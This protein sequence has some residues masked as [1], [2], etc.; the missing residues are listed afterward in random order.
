MISDI[1][2]EVFREARW[3]RFSSW[4]HDHFQPIILIKGTNICKRQVAAITGMTLADLFQPF[5][6]LYRDDAYLTTATL[7][8]K[9]RNSEYGV[10]QKLSKWRRPSTKASTKDFSSTVA[11]NLIE[12][13][14][15]FPL[16]PLRISVQIPMAV[17]S[18][19]SSGSSTFPPLMKGSFGAAGT[20]FGKSSGSPHTLREIPSFRV[21]FVSEDE[22]TY[23][24][25]SAYITEAFRV[26]SESEPD[27]SHLK[28]DASDIFTLPEISPPSSAG[29]MT[30]F[31]ANLKETVSSD[32]RSLPSSTPIGTLNPPE[33][34]SAPV[35]SDGGSD[36]TTLPTSGGE[37]NP[38]NRCDGSSSLPSLSTLQESYPSSVLMNSIDIQPLPL[39]PTEVSA[40]NLPKS[41]TSSPVM[42]SVNNYTPIL[43]N[44]IAGD[45]ELICRDMF[46]RHRELLE[47]EGVELPWYKNWSDVVFR[48]AQWAL[49]EALDQPVGIIYVVSSWEEDPLAALL[50]LQKSFE[51]NTSLLTAGTSIAKSIIFLD[52][53]P[54]SL[55]ECQNEKVPSSSSSSTSL[56]YAMNEQ[57]EEI[58]SH[59]SPSYE[60]YKLSIGRVAPSTL[61]EP[62]T[63]TMQQHI[64]SLYIPHLSMHWPHLRDSTAS[65]YPFHDYILSCKDK[66]LY[67]LPPPPYISIRECIYSSEPLAVASYRAEGGENFPMF[68]RGLNW[69]DLQRIQEIARTFIERAV[70]DCM[71][72]SIEMLDKRVTQARKGIKNQ[73]KLFWRNPRTGAAATAVS[74]AEQAGGAAEA[75]FSAVGGFFQV[76][77][78][79]ATFLDDSEY[80]KEGENVHRSHV[81][82]RIPPVREFSD[83]SILWIGRKLAD[84]NF[85]IRDYHRALLHY[86]GCVADYKHEKSYL[87]LGISAC[88]NSLVFKRV[89][90]AYPCSVPSHSLRCT[91]IVRV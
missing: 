41:S 87:H 63:L 84:L 33:R 83:D 20:A 90:D 60:C 30:S 69:K 44:G 89:G 21:R 71:Q 80:S 75:L 45:F 57:F 67:P 11:L 15:G 40:T 46:Q 3:N 82:G 58:R 4:L 24:E 9:M 36:L 68:C 12:T 38:P 86:K 55:D 47:K 37:R 91:A 22:A 34:F 61:K 78:G 42:E 81:K 18:R 31:V 8:E 53:L 51:A 79:G 19:R 14:T 52:I 76:E 10:S 7:V 77:A 88:S 1:E 54:E 64:R 13:S 39:N 32:A 50:T 73:L 59:F 65:L 16:E 23:T 27:L 6:G 35:V 29:G 74:V 72:E 48:C 56:T 70:I 62:A 25:Q 66:H 17:T 26:M 2:F 43:S 49:H 28:K 85:L 5:G